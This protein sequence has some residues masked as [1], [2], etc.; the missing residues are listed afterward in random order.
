MGLNEKHRRKAVSLANG[1]RGRL[2]IKS[3]LRVKPNGRVAASLPISQTP[4]P[5]RS[6]TVLQLRRGFW[7]GWSKLFYR[8]SASTNLRASLFHA[9]GR[10][11][12]VPVA[13]VMSDTQTPHVSCDD[14]FG[15]LGAAIASAAA[16]D[17]PQAFLDVS[18][19]EPLGHPKHVARKPL[20]GRFGDACEVVLFCCCRGRGRVQRLSVKRIV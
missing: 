18:L 9:H 15:R 7:H 10:V 5:K 19:V 13:I 8:I 12:Q 20:R 6:R 3:P 17:A 4:P 2:G 16:A 11:L 14:H 1:S